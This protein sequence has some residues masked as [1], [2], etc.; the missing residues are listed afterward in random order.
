MRTTNTANIR[1]DDLP[2]GILTNVATY[3][4]APSI[5]LMGF[6]LT[7]DGTSSNQLLTQTTNAIMSAATSSLNDSI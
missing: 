3:L 5:V 2:D 4:A 1:I 6:A 7:Q